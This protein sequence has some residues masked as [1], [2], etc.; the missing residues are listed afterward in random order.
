[1]NGFIRVTHYVPA[2]PANFRNALARRDPGGWPAHRKPRPPVRP[3]FDPLATSMIPLPG[4]RA[5]DLR[6]AA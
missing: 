5:D 4:W 3:V 6:K 1:M 2:D